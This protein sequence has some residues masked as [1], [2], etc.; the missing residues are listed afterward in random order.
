MSAN[1][2]GR[3]PDPEASTESR[4]PPNP[5]TA[6][7]QTGPN[8]WE[9]AEY[10]ALLQQDTPLL[11][12]RAP[13]EFAKGALPRAVNLPLMNDDERHQ[14]GLCYQQKGQQ[15]AI[16]LGLALVS[17]TTRQERIAAWVRFVQAHP[18]GHLYCFRGG[19]RSRIVQHWLAQAG[20]PYPRIVGGYKAVRHFLLDQLQQGVPARSLTVL[21]GLTGTGKT[22]LLVQL[23]SGLDL[24]GY[25]GHRGSSFGKQVRPQPSQIDFEHHLALHLLKS[26]RESVPHLVVEDEG[27]FIGRCALP[28]VLY[29]HMQQAPLVW[30]EDAFDHRV[31]RILHSYVIDLHQDFVR[32]QG[33]DQG[34]ANFAQHLRQ[35]LSGIAK[36]LGGERTQRLRQQMESAL[37]VQAEQGLVTGHRVW[38]ET[39]LHD[40]YDPMYTY[41]AHRKEARIIFRGRAPEVLDYL[42]G[43]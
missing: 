1:D 25:A 24:E 19:L 32:L 31:Q 11:D 20:Y 40:Y 16:D 30:L 21:G 9:T 13:V 22:E 14:V 26:S 29:Q 38:I 18:G 12:V 15:A 4:P 41:Q 34:F 37:S 36:R 17:G 42:R 7:Q 6:T 43:Q 39:L 33:A 28:P 3:Y 23:A 2:F 8:P 5:T 10:G 35:S 27:Q